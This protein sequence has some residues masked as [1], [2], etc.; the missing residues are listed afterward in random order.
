[1][2]V[3]RLLSFWEGLFSG[4]MLNFRGV[5]QIGF[6]QGLVNLKFLG[7][8]GKRE[9]LQNDLKDTNWWEYNSLRYMPVLQFM[10]VY[11]IYMVKL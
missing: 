8:S 7:D 9:S 1:M 4:A 2:M 6:L 11:Y 10:I 5:L 3:G